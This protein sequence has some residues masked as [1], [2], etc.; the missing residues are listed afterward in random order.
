MLLNQTF[1]VPHG[2]LILNRIKTPDGTILTSW[3]QHDYKVYKDKNG[4]VYMVDGGC[5][6]FRRNKCR[7]P[8]EELSVYDTEPF[9]KIR[10]AHYRFSKGKDGK[11]PER[12]VHLC[13]MSDN[14]LHAVI[15]WN[16]KN[17]SKLV[18]D[19]LNKF[20]IMELLYRAEKGIIRKI[21]KYEKDSFEP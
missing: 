2:N 7:E 21:N 9:E 20:Y 4:E 5:A 12:I 14:W 6:Y 15:Q 3:S 10:Q 13:S 8:Y 11:E 19:K 17:F 16:Q 18:A 1:K